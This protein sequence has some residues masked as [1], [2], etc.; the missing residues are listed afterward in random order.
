MKTNGPTGTM[1]P[2]RV[3][4]VEDDKFLRRAVEIRLKRAGY[5]VATACDGEEALAMVGPVAPD[6]VLLDLIMPRMQGFAV[7]D[8]LKASPATANVPV[9]IMSNRGQD[10]D[11]CRAIEAG[12]VKYLIKAEISLDALTHEVDDTLTRV[13][14]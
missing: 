1:T 10:N 2:R 13:G 5:T 14:P 11:R 3:L 12:A 7:L 6:V 8:A 9:I 4:V